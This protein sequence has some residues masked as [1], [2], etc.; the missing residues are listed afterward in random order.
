MGLK[1]GMGVFE[2]EKMKK[3]FF[4]VQWIERAEEKEEKEW[5]RSEGSAEEEV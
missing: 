5:G 1:Q 4:V 3:G 2:A